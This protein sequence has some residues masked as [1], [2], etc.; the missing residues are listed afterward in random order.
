[1]GSPLSSAIPAQKSYVPN[2]RFGGVMPQSGQSA[3]HPKGTCRE[4]T[5][6]RP[7]NMLSPESKSG[8]RQ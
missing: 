2:V 1:M 5:P 8:Q 3:N 4:P 6:L 7:Q